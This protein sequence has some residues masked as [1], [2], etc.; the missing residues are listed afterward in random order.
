MRAAW[1]TEYRWT[2][3]EVHNFGGF[4]G[5]DTVT[6]TAAQWGTN[7][8]ETFTIDA[9]ALANVRE[10]HAVAPSMLFRFDMVAARV[11]RSELLAAAEWPL[12]DQALDPAPPLGHLD[13][14]RIRAYCCDHC[15]LWV[16][17][18]PIAAEAGHVC[19]LCGERIEERRTTSD[20]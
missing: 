17:G 2:V 1:G 7:E 8:E 10:R 15:Q 4:F 19:K 13:R 9:Q 5:G 16:V 6:L 20:E 14:L 18:E 11:D 3:R 12:L